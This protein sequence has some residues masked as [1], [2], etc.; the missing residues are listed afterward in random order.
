MSAYEVLI[1]DPLFDLKDYV[2]TDT[3]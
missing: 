1:N 2:K 3:L